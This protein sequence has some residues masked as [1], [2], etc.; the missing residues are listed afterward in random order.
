[1]IE[2]LFSQKEVGQEAVFVASAEQVL[3]SRSPF[4]DLLA[5][6]RVLDPVSDHVVQSHSHFQSTAHYHDEMVQ[7]PAPVDVCPLAVI[8]SIH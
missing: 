4:S 2:D 5:C 3:R 1:M 8:S 6:D 7:A